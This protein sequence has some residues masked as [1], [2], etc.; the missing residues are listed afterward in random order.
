MFD[1]VI[2]AILIFG[3]PIGVLVGYMWR[4]SIS[5]QRRARYLERDGFRENGF[6]RMCLCYP[7]T[8]ANRTALAAMK[9]SAR[10][11]IAFRLTRIVYVWQLDQRAMIFI[12]AEHGISAVGPP[13]IDGLFSQLDFCNRQ[14]FDSTI[15]TSYVKPIRVKSIVA[16]LA[17]PATY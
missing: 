5:Q 7:R 16:A 3:F 13:N 4:D 14:S 6:A 2:D 17:A 11:H 10:S 15:V 9:F 1:R 12:E 8:A